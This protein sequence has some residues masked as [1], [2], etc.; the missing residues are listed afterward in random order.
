MNELILTEE[1]GD[2]SLNDV[3]RAYY[4]CRKNKRNKLECLEFDLDYEE[5]LIK[6]WEEIKL[7]IHKMEPST[8][9][10]VDKPVKREI[11]AV[12]FK[13]RIVHRLIVLKVR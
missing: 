9:F 2:I 3:F 13:D 12:F 4:L 6:L 11:C 5:N 1:K 10:I 8:V 7:G